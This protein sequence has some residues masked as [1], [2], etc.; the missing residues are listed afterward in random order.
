MQYRSDFVTTLA[1]KVP[2]VTLIFW[3]IKMMSTTV[4]ETAADYLIFQQHL[5]LTLTSALMGTLLVVVLALQIKAVR[6]EPRRYWLAVVLVSIFGTLLTDNLTDRVGI[7]LW[8][9]T[10]V[11]TLLLV[12]FAIWFRHEGTLSIN[13]INT[14]RRE[15]FYWLAIL[16]TFALG[17]AAG[18]W[19]SEGMDIGYLNATL[20]FGGLI[21]LMAV[22]YRVF[23]MNTVL[24]FWIAYVLTRPLG[25]SVG[26][27]LSPSVKHGGLGYGV[28]TVSEAF[29]V[30]ILL[31]VGYLTLRRQAA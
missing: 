26:D 25:A 23:R 2:E 14:L 29:F 18:D 22:A 24:S 27:L 10:S 11:F 17:T 5:G 9:S 1:N 20:L 21:A 16:V 12:T 30:L 4:G 7:P 19:V 13:S 6:Y 28:T 15:K 3:I 31:L 8:L